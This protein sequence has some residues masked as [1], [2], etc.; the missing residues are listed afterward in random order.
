MKKSP[1][2]IWRALVPP[3]GR[4]QKF[5]VGRKRHF[6][7][8]FQVADDATQIDVRKTLYPFCAIRKMPNVTATVANRVPSQKI[9][10][11]QM[12]VLVSMNILILKTEL[13]EFWMNYKNL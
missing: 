11:E 13:A 1:K 4:P 7:C 9:Y 12:F 3:S 2:V 10:T 5:S 6:A 8:Q